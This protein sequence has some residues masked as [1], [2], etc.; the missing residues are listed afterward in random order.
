MNKHYGFCQC[1]LPGFDIVVM[2]DNNT[3]SRGGGT[4][5]RVHSTVYF[6]VPSCEFLIISNDFFFLI[7]NLQFHGGCEELN[8]QLRHTVLILN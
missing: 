1:P 7:K 8:N 5:E 2:Q 6:F 3:G 4:G